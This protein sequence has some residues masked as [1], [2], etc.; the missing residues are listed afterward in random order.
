MKREREDWTRLYHKTL[1][2]IEVMIDVQ[3]ILKD[4]KKLAKEANM[5]ITEAEE[6][7]LIASINNQIINTTNITQISEDLRYM[8]QSDIDN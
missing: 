3:R 2:G 1:K 4:L 8:V 7:I 5:T 6:M